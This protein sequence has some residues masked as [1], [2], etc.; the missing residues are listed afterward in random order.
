MLRP[1]SRGQK[2]G[3]EG[4]LLICD[5]NGPGSTNHMIVTANFPAKSGRMMLLQSFGGQRKKKNSIRS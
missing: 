3:S 1:V 2:G 5:P 4:W